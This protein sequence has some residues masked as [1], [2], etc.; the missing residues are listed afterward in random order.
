MKQTLLNGEM[1]TDLFHE[2]GHCDRDYG[3]YKQVRGEGNPG[4]IVMRMK[5]E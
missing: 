5:Q 2:N 3:Y 4:N 1:I